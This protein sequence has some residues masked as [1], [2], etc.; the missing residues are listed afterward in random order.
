M[1]VAYTG[2]ELPKA[3]STFTRRE[4]L[5]WENVDKYRNMTK[6]NAR[7]WYEYAKSAGKDAQT[8]LEGYQA[9]FRAAED[10]YKNGMGSLLELVRSELHAA[11]TG[12]GISSPTGE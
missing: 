2:V 5:S 9:A 4:T 6:V 12:S 8:A 3:V 11:G 10:R 1:D 7:E